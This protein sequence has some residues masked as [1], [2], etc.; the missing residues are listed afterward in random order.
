MDASI[1]VVARLREKLSSWLGVRAYEPNPLGVYDSLNSSRLVKERRRRGGQLTPLPYTRT[2]W[3]LA[4]LEAAVHQADAG[5]LAQAAQL[6]RDAK[7]DGVFYGVLSTR[8]GG[9]VRLP[10]RFRGAPDIV[11]EL[12]LGHDDA[13]PTS[14]FDE[15][16]PPQELAA[17][18]ADGELLGVAIG[19]LV[20]VP[21]RTYPLLVRHDPE[22]LL[23]NWAENQWYYRALTGLIPV[24]PGDGRWVLHFAGCRQAPWQHGLWRAIGK[25]YIRKTHAALHKD[26]WEGKLANPA[27]VAV[28]PGGSSEAQKQ[29]WFRAVMAWGVNTVFGLTPGYDVKLLESNGRG[30]ES[31]DK[32][33]AE[34]N[35][36]FIIAVAGQTVTTDGGAGFQNSDIHKSIRAD[37]IKASADSIAFTI[38]T[39]VLPTYVEVCHAGQGA[40]VVEWDVAPPKDKNSEGTALTTAAGAIKALTEALAPYGVTVD[41]RAIC[42]RAGVPVVEAGD[43]VDTTAS[44]PLALVEPS[45]PLA[46]PATTDDEVAA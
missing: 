35:E 10:K 37:L 42:T 43:N 27:R 19:E 33:K 3:Y 26:N 22:F 12:E 31:F 46:L 40:V 20:A 44:R 16:C 5:N 45:A 30:W 39:Q 17:M 34:C 28:A 29:D 24:T 9:L 41:V 6:M 11:R 38:N 15:M 14:V 18:I 13:E 21:D 8:T 1:R 23:Y 32:T 25:A 7:S 36:E 2:R 4:D